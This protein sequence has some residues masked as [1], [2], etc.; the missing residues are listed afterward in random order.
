MVYV[1]RA[2]QLYHAYHVLGGKLV[3]DTDTTATLRKGLIC[4]H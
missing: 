2:A 1:R 4:G 3:Q